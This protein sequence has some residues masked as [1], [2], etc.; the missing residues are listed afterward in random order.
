MS[1]PLVGSTGFEIGEALDAAAIAQCRA[2]FA[3]YQRALGI[4]LCFQQ[5]D[6][7]MA[8]LP[9]DYARP[10]GRLVLARVAGE[11]AGCVALRPLGDDVAEMKRLYVR[12]S[13]RGMGIGRT[14]AEHVIDEARALGYRTVKLDTLPAMADAQRLYRKLGFADTPAYNDNPVDGVRFLALVLV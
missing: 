2:L 8:N 11:P 9:G 1:E 7:E 14:L 3:E 5:F 4:S 13:C 10:R 12:A 6:R